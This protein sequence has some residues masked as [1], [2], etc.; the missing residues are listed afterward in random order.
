MATDSKIEDMIK[1]CIGQA[2][3]SPHWLPGDIAFWYTRKSES[4]G[5]QFIFVDCIAGVR[6]EAFDHT[7]LAAEL[8]RR[9]QKEIRPDGLP[10]GWI[11]VAPDCE[12][13]RFKFDGQA[14][15]YRKDGVLEVW[16]GEF[17]GGDFDSGCKEAASPTSHQKSNL[18][19]ENH[20]SGPLTCYWLDHSGEPQF[21]GV[22]GVGQTKLIRSYAGH[23]WRIAAE[24]TGKRIACAT[25]D[26]S[27]TVFVSEEGSNLVLRREMDN[28][29]EDSDTA[30]QDEP[31]SKSVPEAFIRGFNVWAR[32]ADGS[33][34]Q[35]THYGFA[36]D[37]FQED[38]IF[39][40]SDGRHVVV[41]QCKPESKSSAYLVESSPKDGLE[42]KLH[43]QHYLRPGD[44]VNRHRPR[45]FDLVEKRE[46]PVDASLFR[47]PFALTNAGWSRDG[48]KYRFLFNERGH[49]HMRLL[50]IDLDGTVQVLAEDHSKTFID[51]QAK[52][53]YKILESTGEL[54]WASERDGWNHLYLYDLRDG[55]LK[56][57]VTK[58]EWVMRSVES[59]DEEKRLVWFR[60]L[61]MVPGQDPYYVHL[62]CVHL[63]GS[64]LRIVTEGDGTHFWK[65]SPEKRFLIDTWSRVDCPPQASL[66]D[67]ATGKVIVDLEKCSVEPLLEAGWTP[68][69]RFAAPG[70]DGK[71]LVHGI[72]VRPNDFDVSKKYP[73]IEYIYAGPQDYYTPK[74]FDAFPM[75]HQWV[76]DGFVFV[77]LDGMGT[78]WRHKAFHDVCHKDLKDAGFPDRKAWMRAA[79]AASRPWMDL[80]RG[81]GV[82]GSSAGGQNAAGAVLL[83]GDFYTAAAAYAGCHDNRLDKL[84]WNELWMGHPVD[85]S[86]AASSNATHAHR[87]RD[88]AGLMLVVGGMDTNVDPACTMR[89]VDALVEADRDFE[90][91]F[92]PSGNHQL[93]KMPYTTKRRAQFFKKH[94]LHS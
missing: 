37:E 90:L 38:C 31:D 23:I 48:K 1:T 46:I 72:I 40:S 10:F 43:T 9:A 49:Q 32:D 69:E 13:V 68:P 45:L 19:I 57:Q 22:A 56:N 34:G 41:W 16:D 18:A 4:G 42:P 80:A 58:G 44:N 35:I 94:L 52:E 36:D 33:E 62:A 92:V 74:T 63:D 89:F 2:N 85:A 84:W 28:E 6:Q 67:T 75:L 12:W 21:Y 83:H 47:N 7:A 81:V 55:T 66:R 93:V 8:G 79:A 24:G 14:W 73:V 61:G 54:L 15:K 51:Y 82:Y 29:A 77:Q 87:L 25:A 60:G 11:N 39:P 76:L 30:E 17:D 59:V 70:R 86:Y 5:T 91:V 78:N 50:H 26:N 27:S 64:G 65:W 88:G 53:Y 3:V 20:T 71:T